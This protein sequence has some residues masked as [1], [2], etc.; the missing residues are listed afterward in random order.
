MPR[1]AAHEK[2]RDGTVRGVIAS[3][4]ARCPTDDLQLVI[5][6]V[7]D[8]VAAGVGQSSHHIQ[9][10]GCRRPVD[11]IGVVALLACVHVQPALEKKIHRSQVTVMRRQVQQR[12]LVWPVAR[13]Q[14][15]GMLVEQRGEPARI[16]APCG[17]EQLPFDTQRIDVRL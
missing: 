5:V 11:W 15:A 10:A 6:T 16:A 2:I 3:V 7:P 4:P 12:V 14:L 13:L 1:A 17:L 8:N 9:V